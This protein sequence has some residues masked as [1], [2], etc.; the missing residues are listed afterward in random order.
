[1]DTYKLLANKKYYLSLLND[2]YIKS[3]FFNDIKKKINKINILLAPNNYFL[4]LLNEY[5]VNK[6]LDERKRKNIIY[7]INKKIYSLYNLINKKPFFSNKNKNEKE[8]IFLIKY[9]NYYTNVYQNVENIQHYD[10]KF[11][12]NKKIIQNIFLKYFVDEMLDGVTYEFKK[13][14]KSLTYIN[15]LDIIRYTAK[16]NTFN[17]NTIYDNIIR[18]SDNLID[19]NGILDINLNNKYIPPYDIIIESIPV[20]NKK[21]ISNFKSEIRN[22]IFSSNYDTL[23]IYEDLNYEQHLTNNKG[24][25]NDYI[26]KYNFMGKSRKPL[27]AGIIT[28]DTASIDLSI[29]QIKELIRKY[30]YKKIKFLTKVTQEDPSG[31][32]F[33]TKNNLACKLYITKELYNFKKQL[34]KDDKLR[35]YNIEQLRK[36]Y[37]KSSPKWEESEIIKHNS[38]VNNSPTLFSPKREENIQHQSPK[39]NYLPIPIKKT[40]P[41]REENIQHQS[42]KVNYLPIPI[43]KTSPKREENIQHQSPKV[44]YLPIPIK[45]K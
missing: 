24:N 20:K 25:Y 23:Y 22:K 12:K 45:K 16:K 15:I 19:L 5:Y 41:K 35:I 18:Y 42:P 37:L 44:N 6:N 26:R 27:S 14:N 36:K 10:F 8:L 17:I 39:V 38:I 29:Y 7:K 13:K 2:K 43:K 40:S 1:M 21:T 30:K 33:Y 32:S 3:R 34:F 28:Q 31:T 9:I 4:S 11:L